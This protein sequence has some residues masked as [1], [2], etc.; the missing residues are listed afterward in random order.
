MGRTL[1]ATFPTSKTMRVHEGFSGAFSYAEQMCGMENL[2]IW[3]DDETGAVIAMIHFSAHFRNGYLAFY[4]NSRN[5]PIRVKDEGGREVKIKGLRV[6]LEKGSRKDSVMISGGSGSGSADG[7]GETGKEGKE[8]K[9]GKKKSKEDLDRKKFIMGAK[10]EFE[11]E[12][13]KRQFL[14]LLREVQGSM[15]EL[16]ELLGVN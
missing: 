2:R 11:S 3:E 4:L 14:Q 13:E 8:G 16:P 9:E 1:L 15:M 7:S 12:M 6:P 5:S 10:V